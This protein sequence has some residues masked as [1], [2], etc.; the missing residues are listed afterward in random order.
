[1][2]IGDAVVLAQRALLG[3]DRDGLKEALQQYEAER[4]PRTGNSRRFTSRECAEKGS[5]ADWVYGYNA[6]DSPSALTT[7]IG[8]KMKKFLKSTIFAGIMATA[9]LVQTAAAEVVINAVNGT[10]PAYISTRSGCLSKR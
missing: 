2:A 4:K 10:K 7:F 9:A 1:M 3:V 8:G 5:N 6:L